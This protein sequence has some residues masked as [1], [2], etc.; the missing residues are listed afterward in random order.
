MRGSESCVG[1]SRP[2][3]HCSCCLGNHRQ[4][5]KFSTPLF[6]QLG[7]QQMSAASLGQAQVLHA[8]PLAQD[9]QV[10]EVQGCS[11]SLQHSRQEKRC[12]AWNDSEP[13][14]A[15]LWGTP[16]SRDLEDP[17]FGSH[18]RVADG[19]RGQI[20]HSGSGAGLHPLPCRQTPTGIPKS[21]HSPPP[22]ATDCCLGHH[23]S[24]GRPFGCPSCRT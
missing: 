5:E 3:G 2:S 21:K 1:S 10:A 13:S 19:S 16:G 14:L 7:H 18:G 15:A 17:S 4:R 23:H 9:G 22:F 12:R 8:V 11:H 6:R 20:P 24:S